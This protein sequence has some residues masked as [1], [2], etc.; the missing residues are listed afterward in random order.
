MKAFEEKFEVRMAEEMLIE[1]FAPI[2]SFNH[3]PL[4]IGHLYI[5]L[6]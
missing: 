1:A 6:G 5:E 4:L 2:V 3:D